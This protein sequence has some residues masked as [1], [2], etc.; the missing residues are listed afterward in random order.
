[1]SE[2]I[3]RQI[4]EN[5]KQTT[6]LLLWQFGAIK[7][8]VNDPFK[9]VSGNYSPIYINCRLLI[10]H[11]QFMDL[12][13]SFAHW[14]ISSEN[15][16]IDLIAGGE[17]A[18]IPFSAYIAHRLGCPMAYVR[19]RSKEY[20]ISSLVEGEINE[21]Q[22]VLLV[23]DLITDGLSK[24]GFI[25]GLRDQGAIVKDCLVVFDRLQGGSDFLQNIGVTLHSL[26]NMQTS[27]SIGSSSGMISSSDETDVQSY[28]RDPKKWHE[29]RGFE[30]KGEF[31]G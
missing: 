15:I 1:M 24:K 27:L 19:K 11:T 28:L 2:E 18:G 6:A 30:F 20:G 17:T 16:Q 21:G 3:N 31:I 12:F 5:I 8:N 4:K 25:D 9:L 10:S 7:I 23:E 26:C 13:C 22:R 14:L 29:K